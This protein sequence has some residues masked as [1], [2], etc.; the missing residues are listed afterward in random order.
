MPLSK[1]SQYHFKVISEVVMTF[2]FSL[3]AYRLFVV[4]KG[5]QRRKR[6]D[7][8]GTQKGYKQNNRKYV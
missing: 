3:P 1:A 5:Y 6:S 7:K 2:S 4:P 8:G